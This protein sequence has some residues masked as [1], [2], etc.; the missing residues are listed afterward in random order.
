MMGDLLDTVPGLVVV[1]CKL[2]PSYQPVANRHD[3]HLH[4]WCSGSRL[5][6]LRFFKKAGFETKT[7]YGF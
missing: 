2:H 6:V 3:G 4:W 1:R 7:I 5:R